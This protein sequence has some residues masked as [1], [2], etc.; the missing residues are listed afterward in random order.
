MPLSPVLL[1]EIASALRQNKPVV[2]LESTIITHGMPYPRNVETAV[3]VENAVR[4]NGAVPAT[5]ALVGG[6]IKVGLTPDEIDYL[7]RQGQRVH[8]TSRRDI[9]YVAARQLD[10]A[11]TVAATMLI[12][13]MAG[14]RIFATGGIGG[15]HRDAPNSFD[16]SADLRELSQTPVAVVCAGA[17]SILDLPLTLEYLETAGVPVVGYQTTEF[18]AF[19]SRTSGLNLEMS[20]QTPAELSAIL[21]NHWQLP[22]PSGIVIANPIPEA[23][24]LEYGKM[25]SVIEK[26]LEIATTRKISGKD[27]TPFLLAEI[28]RQTDGASLRANIQLVLHNARLAA[29]IAGAFFS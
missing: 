3:R 5:I 8:K 10:G 27:L 25:E 24:A 22:H 29:E 18:P 14:I 19:F 21:K 11:T 4:E 16:I 9:G 26:A 20:A 13:H 7:G 1:P 6:A 2:A 17:K 12:A 28:E 15:V 23:E